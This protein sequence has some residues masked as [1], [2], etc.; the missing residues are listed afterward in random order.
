MVVKPEYSSLMGAR[1]PAAGHF[2]KFVL[3]IVLLDISL[4]I[5]YSRW[6]H[7]WLSPLVNVSVC[8][9]LGISF[10]MAMFTQKKQAL[11]DMIANT[12]VVQ[13]IQERSSETPRMYFR[14]CECP[15]DGPSKPE[16]PECGCEF[17]AAGKSTY[18]TLT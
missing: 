11:H 18:R 8:M 1:N 15:L 2:I 4:S 9:L 12:L 16:C 17:N 7:P 13:R 5:D 6:G 10:I 3:P 14:E